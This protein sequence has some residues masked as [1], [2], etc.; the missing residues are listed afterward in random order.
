[1]TLEFV[2]TVELE[3]LQGK[4]VRKDD[5]AEEVQ[6]EL[7]NVNPGS[8]YV[9]DSE[10]EVT[11]WS[12]A[13][14]ESI[15]KALKQLG[16]RRNRNATPARRNSVRKAFQATICERPECGR[17]FTPARRGSPQKW[18]SAHCRRL[19]WGAAH[20]RTTGTATARFATIEEAS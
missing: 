4:F 16:A 20:P 8:V 2:V 6:G 19:A 18:C 7:E 1:M 11:T 10:Y 12:V 15:A 9:E 14:E 3:R 13:R 17:P 5:L